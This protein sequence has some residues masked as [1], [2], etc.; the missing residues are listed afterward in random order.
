[1]RNTLQRPFRYSG[2]GPVLREI[3]Q[4]TTTSIEGVTF[5]PTKSLPHDQ[6]VIADILVNASGNTWSRAARRR[7]RTES[8]AADVLMQAGDGSP[9]LVCRMR[10][11]VDSGGTATVPFELDTVLLTVDWVRGD[12]RGLFE[13]FTNHVWR[14]LEVALLAQQQPSV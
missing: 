1:M 9:Q 12:D 3:L 8:E 6:V 10:W 2:G 13:S 14:K 5:Q 4:R 7:K 11:L